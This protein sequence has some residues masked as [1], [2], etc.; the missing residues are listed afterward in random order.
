MIISL[1]YYYLQNL[2]IFIPVFKNWSKNNQ[3]TNKQ[4]D[5]SQDGCPHNL[6]TNQRVSRTGWLPSGKLETF[7]S[8]LL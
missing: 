2:P 1:Y 4:T 5:S 3:P 8:K 6:S 7:K